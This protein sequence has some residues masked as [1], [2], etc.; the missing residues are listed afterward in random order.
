[1]LSDLILSPFSPGQHSSLI[2]FTGGPPRM[3]GPPPGGMG[4]PPPGGMGGPP[5]PMGG[6]PPAANNPPPSAGTFQLR[7]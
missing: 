3:G 6:P 4:G 1:M 5:K 2:L 7:D